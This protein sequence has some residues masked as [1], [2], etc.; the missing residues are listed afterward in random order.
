VAHGEGD[1]PLNVRE[2]YR[3]AQPRTWRIN[4]AEERQRLF[5]L[6]R[7]GLDESDFPE[8]TDTL[9]RYLAGVLIGLANEFEGIADNA[10]ALVGPQWYIGGWREAMRHIEEMG[11]AIDPD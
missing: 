3:V 6:A 4:T 7:C 2:R 11:W 9:D 8:F 10:T 5:D 1:R